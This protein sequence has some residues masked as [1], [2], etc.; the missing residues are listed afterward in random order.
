MAARPIAVTNYAKSWPVAAFLAC[1]M[2]VGTGGACTL[3]YLRARGQMGY[4][5]FASNDNPTIHDVTTA[6]T[7]A[8]QL[9]HI[10]AVLQPTVADLAAAIGVSRQAV[11][12][13]MQGKPISG[14]Y[15]NKL[16]ALSDV[17]D[18]LTRE[19]LKAT[20][21]ILRRKIAGGKTMFDIV[22]EGGAV[23]TAGAQLVAILRREAQQRARLEA[24]LGKRAK[25]TR[26]IFEDAGAPAGDE[27]A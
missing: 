15:A 6:R 7:A 21:E 25:P 23:D 1:A 16:S 2:Q 26:D 5:F 18:L 24:R 11:Y 4:E 20:A 22:R 9:E 10:R 19:G 12:G 13:W 8:E 27:R 17:A 14:E 3:E